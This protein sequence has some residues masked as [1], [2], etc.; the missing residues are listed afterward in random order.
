MKHIAKVFKEFLKYIIQVLRHVLD[1]QK[2]LVQNKSDFDPEGGL[3]QG[4]ERN[5]LLVLPNQSKET[6][7]P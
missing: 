5:R 6:V 7:S 1:E 4:N 3:L 2:G